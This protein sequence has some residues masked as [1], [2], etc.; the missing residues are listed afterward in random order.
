MASYVGGYGF[1][2]DIYDQSSLAYLG[3]V[4]P[5]KNQ[6]QCVSVLGQAVKGVSTYLDPHF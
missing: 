1:S 2:V 4:G 3:T 5:L 6:G